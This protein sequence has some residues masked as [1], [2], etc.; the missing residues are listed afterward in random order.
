MVGNE[1]SRVAGKLECCGRQVGGNQKQDQI[2]AKKTHNNLNAQFKMAKFFYY[3]RDWLNEL[4]LCVE[5]PNVAAES[6]DHHA[7]WTVADKVREPTKER[8]VI[9]HQI[10]LLC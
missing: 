4:V 9:S 10:F 3:Y 7:H 5:S 1:Q 8:S 2:V 6:Q